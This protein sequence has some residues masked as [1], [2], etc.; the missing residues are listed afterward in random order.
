M[1]DKNNG[2]P[3]ELELVKTEV[4]APGFTL[5][6]LGTNAQENV[7]WQPGIH[8]RGIVRGHAQSLVA[9]SIFTSSGVMA[10]IS[11]DNGH[12]NWVNWRTGSE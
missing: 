10:M 9:I 3:F 1:P 2:A 8:Y 11:D 6:T 7:S 4:V 5:G 12:G